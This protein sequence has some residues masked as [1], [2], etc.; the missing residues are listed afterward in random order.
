MQLTPRVRFLA[1][2]QSGASLC[3]KCPGPFV[4]TLKAYVAFIR[5]DLLLARGSFALL[6]DKIRSY[7]T[8]TSPAASDAIDRICRA[9]DLA[10]IWYWKEILCLQRSA[11]TTCLLRSFGVPAE[12]L[13]G[14]Q[15]L[16]FHAHAWVEVG[17]CVV[18]DKP[19]MREMYEVLDRC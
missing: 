1:H 2:S 18:S 13:I 9:V 6:H 12:M 15:Q 17:G 3:T 7:P 8:R 4:L 19:Y 11:A 16:P 14:V 10:S 5:I